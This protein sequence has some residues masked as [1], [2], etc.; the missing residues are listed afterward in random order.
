MFLHSPIRGR[1]GCFQLSAV[2]NDAAV[3]LFDS[4]LLSVLLATYPEVELLAHLI[5]LFLISFFEERPLSFP[6]QL[7][8]FA[9]S[10]AAHRVPVSPCRH[11]FLLPT[12]TV[13]TGVRWYLT[14][15]FVCFP[16]V[17]GGV[18]RLGTCFLAVCR[19]FSEKCLSKCPPL[20]CKYCSQSIRFLH[21]S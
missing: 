8:H 14:A 17:V 16:L 1:L 18:E 4:S 20:L 13:P 2:V 12:V 10:R 21:L 5:I 15:G 11:C 3:T 6:K 19:F 9:F 7:C